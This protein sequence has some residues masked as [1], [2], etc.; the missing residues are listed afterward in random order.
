MMMVEQRCLD[1]NWRTAWLTMDMG[2][3]PFEA[4]ARMDAARKRRETP[5][6]SLAEPTWISS[7]N[8]RLKEEDALLK[9]RGKGG[10]KKGAEDKDD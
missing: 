4:W 3:P 6:A 1:G 10:G 2:S 7:I 9:R 5:Q 8:N